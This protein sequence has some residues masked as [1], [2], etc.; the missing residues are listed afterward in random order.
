MHFIWTNLPKARSCSWK[1]RPSWLLEES[2]LRL[3]EK[4]TYPEGQALV[5]WT[6]YE[7]GSEQRAS[8]DTICFQNSSSTVS[9]LLVAARR[10]TR[11][12]E[13]RFRRKGNLGIRQGENGYKP[14]QTS[15]APVSSVVWLQNRKACYATIKRGVQY[16]SKSL[17]L[18]I[19]YIISQ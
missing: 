15:A 17:S 16:G 4:Y 8:I 19:A 3:C 1:N 18:R 7:S 10:D 11:A 2:L 13:V 9:Q 5:R 6:R 14:T 12:S